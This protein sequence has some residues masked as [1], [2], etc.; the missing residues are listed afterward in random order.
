MA[1]LVSVTRYEYG[2]N[3]YGY[4]AVDT[5]LRANVPNLE[6]LNAE[7]AHTALANAGAKIIWLK[8]EADPIEGLYALPTKG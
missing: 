6:G 3:Q 7:Q 1:A 2:H 4:V 8:G 5:T